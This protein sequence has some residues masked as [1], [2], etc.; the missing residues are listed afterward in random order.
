MDSIKNQTTRIVLVALMG[1]VLFSC[2]SKDDIKKKVAQMAEIP[3]LIE[4]KDMTIWMPDS[5]IYMGNEQRKSLTF[6]VYA[7]STQCSPCFI[8]HLKEWEEMLKLENDQRHPVQFLF[9]MEPRKGVSKTLCEK[10]KESGFRHS[11]LIDENSLFRKANPQIP[12][13]ALY[14]TFLLDEDNKVILV[15]NPLRSEE[16][17]KLFYKRQNRE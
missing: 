8:N 2:S 12:E 14:H 10:L 7:D 17:E 3:I 11:V 6:V 15:G 13:D 9:I 4:E 1:L 16:I 5:N